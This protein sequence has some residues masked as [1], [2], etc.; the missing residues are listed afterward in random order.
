MNTKHR[1]R[2]LSAS[3]T[4]ADCNCPLE[5]VM[6]VLRD[7]SIPQHLWWQLLPIGLEQPFFSLNLQAWL[8]CNLTSTL[9]HLVW[10]L[11]WNLLF[12]SFVCHTWKRKNDITF[13]NMPL[14][15]ETLLTVVLSG[16]AIPQLRRG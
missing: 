15:D 13:G 16:L 14:S 5:T 2:N 7:C 1:R 3:S 4:C 9:L 8:S 6:H 12:T 10:N 11:P